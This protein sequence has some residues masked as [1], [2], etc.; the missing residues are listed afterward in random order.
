MVTGPEREAYRAAYFQAGMQRA[1]DA[2]L[3]LG[4]FGPVVR[5]LL[6]AEKERFESEAGRLDPYDERLGYSR[7]G[8]V[9]M[10]LEVVDDWLDN[11]PREV[12]EQ[13]YIRRTGLTP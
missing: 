12:V 2:D 4:E 7:S 1:M 9:S 8:V 6:A 5:E 13:D 3:F 11:D 10:A